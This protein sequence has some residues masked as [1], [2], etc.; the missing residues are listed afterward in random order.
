[1]GSTERLRINSGSSLI[2]SGKLIVG[3]NNSHPDLQ[4]GSANGYNI[5]VATGV[6]GFSS[7]A[8]VAPRGMLDRV[9]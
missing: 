2:A 7:S 4:L 9:R 8:Q 3:N 6:G 5:G 1:M